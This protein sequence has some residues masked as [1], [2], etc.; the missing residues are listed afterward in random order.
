MSAQ[1]S[2]SSARAEGVTFSELRDAL[3]FLW[4][5]FRPYRRDLILGYGA[6]LLKNGAGAS[7]PLII[8]AGVDSL[9][10]GFDLNVTLQYC[11]WMVVAI[12]LKG[13]FQFWMRVLIVNVSRDVEYDL[14]NDIFGNLVRLSGDFYG[15]TRTGDVLARATND[16]GAVRMMAGPAVMYWMET[17]TLAIVVLS[18]MFASDWRLTLAALIPAPIVS[19]AV[20]LLGSK[21]HTYFQAIQEKFSDIS[22]MVQENLQGVRVVRAYVQEEAEQANFARLNKDYIA[23]NLKLAKVSGLF[24]PLLEFLIGISFLMVLAVG[25]WQMMR[26]QMTVGDYVM[27]NSFMGL[28]VWPMIAMGWV[29]NLTQRG[30]ASLK[31]IR[32]FLDEQ[33]SIAEPS[34]PRV[35]E[36]PDG[37]ISLRNVSYR[38]EHGFAL[39]GINLEIPAGATVAIVGPTGSGK[40]TLAKLIPRLIDPSEGEVLVDGVPVAQQSLKALRDGIAVVPQETFLFSSSVLENICFGAPSASVEQARAAAAAAGLGPDLEGFPDGLDTRVGERG[41]TLSGGQKQRT[42]I[43]RALLSNPRILILDDALASVDNITEERILRELETA[44][45]GRTT[46]LISHRISTIRQA[47]RIVVLQN[48][49]IVESGSH[50]ELMEKR[51]Y[52]ADLYQR[53]LIEAELESIS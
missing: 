21:I 44:M 40:S 42:A 43:A 50:E 6:L 33:P 8:K 17:V 34:Q 14:R 30:M 3:Q 48:G 5:Y 41:V 23:H 35:P 49:E 51:G 4:P 22:S 10:G 16:L 31:R 25:G 12:F 27:F 47:Q 28:L 53:Q 19:I 11:G 46:I 18:I 20:S 13:F 32:E 52:Y 1:P 36:A 45:R 15:R 24:M 37:R 7:M 26:G 9:G 29:V 38:H 2:V 39:R